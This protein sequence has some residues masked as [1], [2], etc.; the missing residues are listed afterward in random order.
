MI[1]SK[2]ILIGCAALLSFFQASRA[3]CQKTDIDLPVNQATSYKGEEFLLIGNAVRGAGE[4]VIAIN[5]RNPDNII[6]G[7]MANNHY[8]EGQARGPLGFGGPPVAN[9]RNVY[10]NT[11][12][13]SISTYAISY[14]RGRTWQYFDD[15]FRDFFKMNT[16]ADA[17]VGAGPDG[18][19]F[20]GA[21]N[22]FPQ[23]A[24]PLMLQLEKEPDPGLLYGTIDIASSTDQGKTW[25]E[26]SHVMGQATPIE[27]YA[28]GVKPHFRGKTPYDRG[29]LVIDQSTGTLYVPGNG[30]GGDPVHYESFF[31]VSKD[32]G[33][34]WGLVYSFDS[35]EY[36]QSGVSARP[37]AANG[38]LALAYVASTVPAGSAT[39][40]CPCAVFETSRDEG[41]TFDRH[42][43]QTGTFI[44]RGFG[45][46]GNPSLASDPSH[47][48]RFAVMIV[49]SN[50]E[51]QVYVT[52]DYGKSWSAPVS[53]GNVPGGTVVRPDMSYSPEGDLAVMWLATLADKT[54]TVWS[55]ASH[56]G[57]ATFSAPIKISSAPSPARATIK[58]RGNNRDGDDLSSLVVDRDYVHMVWADGRAGFLGSWYARIP[59]TSYK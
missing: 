1:R 35:P 27:E 29:F 30:S 43:V 52:N 16:T 22:F 36:P 53:A 19:L 2:Q 50:A 55:S 57:G 24:T 45:G 48:G 46:F 54:Y 12:G 7:A 59:L 28:P 13:S 31:R 23:N 21:M 37:A 10:R 42:V 11:P 38:V 20:I 18:T 39:G 47:P 25:S 15:P 40:N 6:V 8:V 49:N 44:Q 58:D 3:A 14:D 17:F 34:T 26:P 33:K 41:K 9:Y 32:N 4:P 5:P 56:D 51:L